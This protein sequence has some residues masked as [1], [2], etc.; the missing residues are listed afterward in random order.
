MCTA[1]VDFIQFD[2]LVDEDDKSAGWRTMKIVDFSVSK[3]MTADP[4]PHAP[5]VTVT[6]TRTLHQ[7]SLPTPSP[8]HRFEAFA[9]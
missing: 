2:D 4:F 6:V 5:L 3:G 9:K 8:F 1:P 7:R